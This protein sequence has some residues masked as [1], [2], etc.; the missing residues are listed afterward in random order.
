MPRPWDAGPPPPEPD[1]LE[2]GVGGPERVSPGARGIR[3]WLRRSPAEADPLPAGG[4]GSDPAPAGV[5]GSGPTPAGVS[6]SDPTGEDPARGDAEGSGDG[7]VKRVPGGGAVGR[8]GLVVAVLVGAVLGGLLVHGYDDR[9]AEQAKRDTVALTAR[10]VPIDG[11][12]G[13]GRDSWLLRL[14]VANRGATTL[15]LRSATLADTPLRSSLRPVSRNVTLPAGKEAWI[16]MDVSGACAGGGLTRPPTAIDAIVTTGDRGARRDRADRADRT[17]R[18]DLSD[19]T[20]LLLSS[21]R[22]T[23]LDANFAL[24]AAAEEAGP[25]RLDRNGL[26]IPVRFRSNR[27]PT[28]EVSAVRNAASGLAATVAATLPMRFTDGVTPAATVRWTI[29]DCVQAKALGYTDLRLRTTLTLP[30][31]TRSIEVTTTLSAALSEA[32]A[33]FVRHACA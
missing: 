27:S 7:V 10:V 21:A 9:L 5:S 8:R 26:T 31:A 20:S 33:V 6:G 2:S 29:T 17:V 4:S 28:W 1:L 18:I 23:C 16:S 15:T 19:D 22:Q 13:R 11:P 3:A 30:D 24:W 32:V 12:G 25:A 14:V